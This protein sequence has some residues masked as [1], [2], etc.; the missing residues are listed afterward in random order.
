MG[1][2]VMVKRCKRHHEPLR[3]DINGVTF[4]HA[5]RLEDER[6]TRQAIKRHDPRVLALA[7]YSNGADGLQTLD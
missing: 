1:G 3:E 5:C 2:A 7:G 6:D 4:C